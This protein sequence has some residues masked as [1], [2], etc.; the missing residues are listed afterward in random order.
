MRYRD[1]LDVDLYAIEGDGQVVGVIILGTHY[2]D[3]MEGD[4]L[5][6]TTA[7]HR[8]WIAPSVQ[9]KGWGGRALALALEHLN[10][11]TD[12]ARTYMGSVPPE[13][14]G[15]LSRRGFYQR[16]DHWRAPGSF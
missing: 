16:G 11:F 5:L 10:D 2:P 3:G 6:E 1:Q 4:S 15:A 8:L 12:S 9:G 7:I 13:L 14:A